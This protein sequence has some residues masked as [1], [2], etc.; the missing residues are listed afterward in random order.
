[1][2]QIA[3]FSDLHL[4]PGSL[5]R[6]SSSDT[7]LLAFFDEVEA[8]VDEVVVAGDLFDLSRPRWPMGWRR[9]LDAIRADHEA[10]VARLESYRWVWGNHDRWLRHNGV[11]ETIEYTLD[12]LKIVILH[13]H[14]FDV[15]LKRFGT[16]E[17]AA[18][19]VAGWAHRINLSAVSNILHDV[20]GLYESRV[21]TDMSEPILHRGARRLCA[22]DDWNLIVMGHSHRLELIDLQ[23]CTFAGGG[24]LCDGHL[25]WVRIDTQTRQIATIRDG[26]ELEARGFG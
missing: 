19:F 14:Q 13:G 6:C 12:G 8:C 17:V 20:P 9:H 1:M 25:E 11:P 2:T 15:G 5:N 18:N 3:I 16:L 26:E 7:E 23:S 24:S 4:A 10:V 22:A 21:E